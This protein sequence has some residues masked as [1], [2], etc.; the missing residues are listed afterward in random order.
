MF[1]FP[2]VNGHLP[3]WLPIWGGEEFIF[4]RPVFNIADASISIGVFLWIIFQKRF[5]RSMETPVQS[6]STISAPP[7][8]SESV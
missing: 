4:F 1:Y 8:P 7:D 2:I 6:E 3:S 5:M